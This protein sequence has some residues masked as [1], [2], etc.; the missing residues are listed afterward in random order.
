[1]INQNPRKRKLCVQNGIDSTSFH[2][3]LPR[4]ISYLTELIKPFSN[5][6][7]W[8]TI[9]SNQ[10]WVVIEISCGESVSNCVWQKKYHTR[11]ISLSVFRRISPRLPI[12]TLRSGTNDNR[13]HRKRR[14][15]F[16][17]VATGISSFLVIQ[18]VCLFSGGYFHDDRSERNEIHSRF[19]F[20]LFFSSSP[21]MSGAWN[22]RSKKEKLLCNQ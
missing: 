12:P 1:M 21:F 20:R 17:V 9:S 5:F 10:H 8:H 2:Q 13:N 14:P 11:I 18:T 4:M 6:H 3:K 16:T 19:F 7:I 15:S 22:G